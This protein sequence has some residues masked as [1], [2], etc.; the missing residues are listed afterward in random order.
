MVAY[1]LLVSLA[2]GA[3]FY[4][5]GSKFS[6]VQVPIMHASLLV[7]Q[8]S[9]ITA[10]HQTLARLLVIHHSCMPACHQPLFHACL[11]VCLSSI[12]HACLRRSYPHYSLPTLS[13]LTGG[14]SQTN[15]LNT[16]HFLFML[17]PKFA[18]DD[19]LNSYATM[20]LT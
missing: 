2:N 5:D 6:V 3:S 20:Q 13:A 11:P 17:S 10:C 7:I 4:V 8:R 19:M 16:L 18:Q 12:T 14:E 9:C 1:E 15:L